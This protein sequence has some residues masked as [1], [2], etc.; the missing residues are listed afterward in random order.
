MNTIKKQVK[1]YL[2][3]FLWNGGSVPVELNELNKYFRF[4]GAI[5]FDI[6]K[7]N[8]ELIA[9]SKDFIYG[10]IVTSAESEDELDKN[11][12]DAILTSFDIPSSYKKEAGIHNVGKEK[13]CYAFA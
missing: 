10:S 5:N 2:I 13:H 4:N 1:D 11:I 12:Q 7:E 3:K 6:K 9:V 8:G